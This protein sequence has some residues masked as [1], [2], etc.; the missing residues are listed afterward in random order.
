MKIICAWCKKVTKQGTGKISH[1]ICKECK[2]K[3]EKE[4]KEMKDEKL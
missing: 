2:D 3:L 1:S 4:I